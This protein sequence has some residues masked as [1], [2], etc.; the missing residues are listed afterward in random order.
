MFHEYRYRYLVVPV[1]YFDS[2]SSY[3]Y[4]HSTSSLRTAL[5]EQ[6]FFFQ[7]SVGA[8]K[9]TWQNSSKAAFPQSFLQSFCRFFRSF[10][11]FSSTSCRLST[12][13]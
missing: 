4:Y 2:H 9:K 6:N 5:T 8:P 12:K 13:N 3:Y 11:H 7:T 1:R 10:R